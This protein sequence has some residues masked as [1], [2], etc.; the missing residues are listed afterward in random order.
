MMATEWADD[1]GKKAVDVF[2]RC[3]KCGWDGW[4]QMITSYGLS[5]IQP[6]EC[7]KC[8]MPTEVA[9]DENACDRSDA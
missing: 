3:I 9:D 8:W 4:G 1:P 2:V 5:D 7:P 6:E